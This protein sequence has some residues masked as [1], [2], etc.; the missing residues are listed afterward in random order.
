MA[1][2]A[3]ERMVDQMV[4]SGRIPRDLRDTYVRDFESGL[5]DQLLKGSDYTKKT[6]QLAQER[7]QFQEAVEQERQKILQERQ[8]LDQWRERAEGELGKMPELTA[9]LAA[10][11]QAL[12][13]YKLYEEVNLPPIGNSP[14]QP[15]QYQPRQPQQHQDQPAGLTREEAANYIRDL[16]MLNGKANRIG[17]QHMKLYG[18]PLEED[19]VSHF[20]TTGQDMDEYWRVKYGVEQKQREI[21][22]KQEE[23]REAAL[24][25]KLRAELQAEYSMNPSLVTGMPAPTFGK[26]T[27]VMETYAASRA[28]THSQNHANDNPAPK[29]DEFVPPEKRSDI[30]MARRRIGSASRMFVEN[31][32]PFG[33]PTTQ[34]GTDLSKRYGS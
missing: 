11:E 18:E 1:N 6:Q 20:L 29:A 13:D 9:R 33:N 5:G 26:Q 4:A 28:T 10:A 24:K 31:F 7:R 3:I 34:R 2:E 22:A 17:I 15:K 25:E 14:Q 19:L 12:K 23:A 30:E 21:Q 32:D 27:P 16:T 8:R